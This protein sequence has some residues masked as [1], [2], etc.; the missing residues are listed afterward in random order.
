MLCFSFSGLIKAQLNGAYTIGGTSP[1]YATIADALTAAQAGVSGPVT[2]NIRPGTYSG[3]IFLNSI[4]GTSIANTVTFQSEN[5][6]STSVIITD[7]SSTSSS[8]DF[9]VFVNGADFIRFHQLTIERSGTLTYRTVIYMGS[10]STNFVV[11]NCIVRTE[12]YT[13]TTINSSLVRQPV[14]QAQDSLTTFSNNVFSGG[15]Y[16]INMTGISAATKLK[17]VVI[18]NNQFID[19]GGTSIML[20]NATGAMITGNDINATSANSQ[21]EGIHIATSVATEISGNRIVSQAGGGMNQIFIE[22]CASLVSAPTTIYNNF[23]VSDGSFLNA[24]V[25]V[26]KSTYVNIYHNSVNVNST[27]ADAACFRNEGSGSSNVEVLNNIFTN[28]GAGHAFLISPTPVGSVSAFDYNNLYTVNGATIGIYDG[29]TIVDVLDLQTNHSVGLNSVSSDPQYISSTDLH[30]GSAG[31][32][33]LGIPLASVTTDIDGESRSGTSPDLGADEFTPLSDNVS[34]LDLISPSGGCGD[35]ATVIGIVIKNLGLNSQAPFDIVADVVFPGGNQMITETTL[36]NLPSNVTDTFYFAQTI[37]TY[38]G[39]VLDLTVYL[40]LVAD[41]YHIND[42]VRASFTYLDHP[43]APTVVSPQDQCDNNLAITATADS[44]DVL[45][46][47]ADATSSDL[48][49]SGAVFSPTV[50]SDTTFYVETR[51]GSGNSGCL[52]IV[53]MEGNGIGDY[54]EL[55]NVSGVSFDATGYKVIASDSY[56]DINVT[57]SITWDLDN[58]AAGEIKYRTD[59][60]SDNYWGSNLLWEPGNPGWA[61]IIDPLGNIVDFVALQW[62]SAT[63]QSLLINV[64]G[65]DIIVGSEWTGDG[66]PTGCGTPGQTP[67]RIGN[68]DNN[69]AVDWMCDV[70]SKG[71]QN[72]ML[73]TTFISCG[74]GACASPRLPI[75]IHLIPG[76][77]ATLGPDTI[78]EAPFMIPLSPG[79]GYSSYLWSTGETTDTIF[80]TTADT[81]WVTVSGPNGCTITDSIVVS[82]GVGVNGQLSKDVLSFYPNP[83]TDKLTIKS[84]SLDLN[85]AQ[86]RMFDA[87]GAMISNLILTQENNRSYVV[88]LKGFESGIYFVQVITDKGMRTER[89][90]VVK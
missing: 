53:E 63:I 9:T 2:F 71:T 21:Y 38:N 36:N 74:V 59:D 80:V 75:D 40:D 73:A 20:T 61:M 65:V 4:Q 44:G 67:N 52:R 37:N 51:H 6:D 78:A 15:S 24:G 54:I 57:N 84:G 82:L 34:I 86:I 66:T 3:K 60:A 81:Y 68:E 23:I 32:N 14:A 33:D 89:L 19:Q 76:V 28:N 58:F 25:A 85:K 8:S 69:S 64:N 35:S 72:P 48:L 22:N 90:S 62:D 43:N 27:Y 70:S 30:A 5:G 18:Q 41:Q 10:N 50:S 31:V 79:P 11:S 12:P 26:D 47:Y 46:W 42:T 87:R 45:M 13:F 49:Y 1:D 55:Q 7:S 16:G 77:V 39:G 88:D 83:A 17:N 56:T 29:D